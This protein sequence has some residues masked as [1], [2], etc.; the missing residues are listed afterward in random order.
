M[1]VAG[2]FFFFG[3]VL[4][5]SSLSGITG[6]SVFEGSDYDFGIYAAIWFFAAGAVLLL[7]LRREEHGGLE[8]KVKIIR[9]MR[10][11]KAVKGHNPKEIQNAIDKIG[12]GAGREHK[13]H[14]SSEYEIRTTKGG[15]IIFLY[16]D[17]RR[18]ATLTRYDP[19]HKY[20]D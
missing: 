2:S 6:Y 10:F 20:V 8:D 7:M 5:F 16:D 12:T 3:A 1:V 4:L 9:T 19:K 14:D 13:L 17:S 18:T 15:R 11:D